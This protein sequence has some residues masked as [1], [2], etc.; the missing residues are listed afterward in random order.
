MKFEKILEPGQIGTLRIKNRIIKACGGAED[1]GALTVT[2]LI[3]SPGA[4]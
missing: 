1:V 2:F 4:E 3:L